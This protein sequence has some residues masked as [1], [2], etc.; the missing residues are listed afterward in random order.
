MQDGNALKYHKFR[1][2]VNPYSIA[3]S[4]LPIK[5]WKHEIPTTPKTAKI[6]NTQ[7]RRSSLAS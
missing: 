2:E 3:L 5:N 6:R 7:L 1:P 4:T